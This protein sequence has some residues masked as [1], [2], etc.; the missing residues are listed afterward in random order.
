MRGGVGDRIFTTAS[1]TP[2]I[3]CGLRSSSF[4]S[5]LCD[6]TLVNSFLPFRSGRQTKMIGFR[7]SSGFPNADIGR[8]RLSFGERQAL[9]S[10]DAVVDH[11]VWVCF[12]GPLHG[13]SISNRPK[14]DELCRCSS[15]IWAIKSVG[16]ATLHPLLES[17]HS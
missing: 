8:N 2:N 12:S 5:V 13:R 7:L 11:R 6:D 16:Q 4:T 1:S 17:C 9:V 14:G 10:I 3:G 15:F